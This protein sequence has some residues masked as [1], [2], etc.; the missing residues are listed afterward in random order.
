MADSVAFALVTREDLEDAAGKRTVQQLF[1]K[2]GGSAGEVDEDLLARKIEQGSSHAASVFRTGWSDGDVEELSNDPACRLHVAWIVMQ[3]ATEGRQEFIAADGAGRY[4]KPFERAE[5]FIRE[6][7]KAMRRVAGEKRAG[8]P[9]AAS[10]NFVK[11]DVPEERSRFVFAPDPDTG[12]PR[13]G[14]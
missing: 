11:P 12:K 5:Q 10:G 8:P 4:Q 14:F 3:F 2:P 7:A 13:G 1:A 9:E 6:A